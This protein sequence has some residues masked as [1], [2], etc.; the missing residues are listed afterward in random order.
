MEHT[1]RVTA[2]VAGRMAAPMLSKDPSPS[3]DAAL[4]A[5]AVWGTKAAV[6]TEPLLG[7]LAHAGIGGRAPMMWISMLNPA[8]QAAGAGRYGD[9]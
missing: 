3:A 2:S 7:F 6:E 1:L 5:T 8:A 9:N 4:W